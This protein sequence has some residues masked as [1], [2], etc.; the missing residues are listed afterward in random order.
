M[1]KK[2]IYIYNK[3]QKYQSN[4]EYR[5]VTFI[6]GKKDIMY[7]IKELIKDKIS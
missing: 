2:T 3:N 7:I 6:N 4:D 1:E 5:I